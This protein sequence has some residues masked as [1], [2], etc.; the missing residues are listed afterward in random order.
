MMLGFAGC[1]DEGTGGTG[2]TGASAGAG[3]TAGTAG[4]AG[5]P[6]TGGTTGSDFCSTICNSPCVGLLG[7]QDDV[8]AC[9]Q[10]CNQGGIFTG[11]ESETTAFIN[12]LDANDCGESGGLTECTNQALAFSQCFGQ[13]F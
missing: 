1:G 2:G 13:G 12:C 4:T 6:G 7:M 5:T 8:E 10:G 9:L 3:G 11:C